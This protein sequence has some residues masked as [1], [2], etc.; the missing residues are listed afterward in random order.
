LSLNLHIV[1]WAN[2]YS[3]IL[4]YFLVADF[5]TKTH[6]TVDMG[7]NERSL[8]FFLVDDCLLRKTASDIDRS[9]VYNNICETYT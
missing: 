6:N 4:F 2:R 9:M 8:K 7:I 5:L 3:F 1:E